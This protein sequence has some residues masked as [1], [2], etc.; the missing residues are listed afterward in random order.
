ME[1]LKRF[2]SQNLQVDITP[3]T[4]AKIIETSYAIELEIKEREKR[5]HGE[6]N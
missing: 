6:K 1:V 4:V 3:R 2:F 5:N